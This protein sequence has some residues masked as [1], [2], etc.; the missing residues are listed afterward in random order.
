MPRAVGSPAISGF[1][2]CAA[3]GFS[4]EGDATARSVAQA[5]KE[6]MHFGGVIR[7]GRPLL[8]ILGHVKNG[9]MRFG[10]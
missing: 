5:M 1:S 9:E 10:R 3:G 4:C 8:T 6:A 7:S 2:A